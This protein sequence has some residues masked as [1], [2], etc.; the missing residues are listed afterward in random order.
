MTPSRRFALFRV[1]AAL[2]ILTA[3]GAVVA[4]FA[5][6]NGIFAVAMLAVLTWAYAAGCVFALLGVLAKPRQRLMVVSLAV[7]AL[8]A[9]AIL[10][11]PQINEWLDERRV[12]G[13]QRLID[14]QERAEQ[15]IASQQIDAALKII[16]SNDDLN[17]W[18]LAD[19]AACP[20]VGVPNDRVVRAL[21]ERYPQL[22]FTG[23]G[24]SC[25]VEAV[26]AL[27]ALRLPRRAFDPDSLS[28][29]VDPAVAELL[30]KHGASANKRGEDGSTPLMFKRSLAMIEWLLTHGADAKAVDTDGRGVLHSNHTQCADPTELPAIF[31]RLLQAGAP[32][33]QAALA[34][35]QTP[36]MS[37]F[38]ERED[39]PVAV[40]RVLVQHG[41][42]PLAKDCNE[43]SPAQ[44][45][46]D[47]TPSDDA[48]KRITAL[49][50]WWPI[51]FNSPD[52]SSLLIQLS[53]SSAT[54][55]LALE[56]IKQGA[57]PNL[58]ARDGTRPIDFVRTLAEP[59]ADDLLH[60]ME[61]AK[62]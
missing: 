55:D 13:Y 56:L 32:V 27:L 6:R 41:A 51:A 48:G 24:V 5:A 52:G 28:W 44:R 25:S 29:V 16:A 30:A 33:D 54:R 11:T 21:L 17:I 49:R 10:F 38:Q 1:L 50:E 47:R 31:E 40:A 62:R 22:G 58:P 26:A 9:V 61:Q 37:F 7:H 43:K 60:E 36:L 39:T 18:T 8:I 3:I 57:D 12:A 34:C 46:L 35:A 45:F 59:G 4:M 19:V 15:F 14:D 2:E 23:A 20:K 53:G 42:D